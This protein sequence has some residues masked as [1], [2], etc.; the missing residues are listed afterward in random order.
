[1]KKLSGNLT[2]LTN[3]APSWFRNVGEDVDV[4]SSTRIRLARNIMHYRFPYHS[5]VNERKKIFSEIT[6]GIA[7]EGAFK[8]FNVL[9]FST[10]KRLE[11]Q[12]LTEERIVSTDLMN[13]EGDRGAVF[14]LDRRTSIMINE[15]DHLRIQCLESGLCPEVLWDAVN[16][17]DDILGRKFNY[18]FDT[19]R[20]YLT[21]CPTNSGT[22]LRISFLLHL[23]G[24]VLTKAIDPVLLGA[25]QM[26]ISARGFFGE[27]SEVVG[28]FFQL[29]NQATMGAHEKDFIKNTTGIIHEVINHERKARERILKDAR[30]ELTD[31]IYRSLGILLYARTLTMSE[32]LNLSSALRFGILS[33]I[34][35][36]VTVDTINEMTI[37]SMPAHLQLLQGTGADGYSIDNLRAELVRKLLSKPKKKTKNLH[38]ETGTVQS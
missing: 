9:N 15:E 30:N 21:C 12:F 38:S 25:S 6:E 7:N 34:Y 29:S 17:T 27:H 18:A 13:M 36:G 2:Q 8:T 22:G 35:D 3:G 14:D 1:M 20:G 11:Q 26:G 28:N 31:K 32:F 37:L 33:G 5:S 23:P 19:R 10:L 16:A 24:L 4:V